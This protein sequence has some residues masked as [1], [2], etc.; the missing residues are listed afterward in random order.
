MCDVLC[1]MLMP[2]LSCLSY[3]YNKES[4]V[5]IRLVIITTQAYYILY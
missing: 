3:L 5:N 4:L 1:V 2:K